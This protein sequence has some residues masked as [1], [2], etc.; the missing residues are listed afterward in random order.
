MHAHERLPLQG[1]PS[2]ERQPPQDTFALGTYANEKAGFSGVVP[3]EIGKMLPLF[4][5]QFATGSMTSAFSLMSW[6]KPYFSLKGG[7]LRAP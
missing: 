2:S 6:T 3:Q 5:G 1:S 4:A 7:S